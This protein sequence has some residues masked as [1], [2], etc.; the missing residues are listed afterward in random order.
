MRFFRGSILLLTILGLVLSSSAQTKVNS[1]KVGNWVGTIQLDDAS[2]VSDMPFNFKYIVSGT[3][4][5]TIEITNAGEIIM[6]KEVIVKGD[7][8]KMKLPIFHS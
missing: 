4:K 5:S 2:H 8:L 1:L 3:G 7:S 6:V